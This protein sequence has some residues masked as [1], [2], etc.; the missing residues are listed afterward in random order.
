MIGEYEARLQTEPN[1][2]KITRELAKLYSEKK[3]FDRALELF[4]KIKNSEMGNDPSLERAIND[5]I[6]RRF[7][8]QLEQLTPRRRITPNSR[9][10]FRR[11]S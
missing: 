8:H 10:K 4:D 5:T 11:R 2:L 6:V 1:N 9:P 7:D 3:Q